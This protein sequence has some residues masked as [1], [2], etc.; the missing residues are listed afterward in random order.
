MS[1]EIYTDVPPLSDVMKPRD[2][3]LF[4]LGGA[5]VGFVIVAISVWAL[6]SLPTILWSGLFP[7]DVGGTFLI[8]EHFRHYVHWILS[9]YNAAGRYFPFYW[10]FYTAQYSIF[11]L[12]VGSYF[13]VQSL[14]FLAAALLTCQIIYRLSGRRTYAA[15][16]LPLIYVSSP[17]AENLNTIGKAEPL[18]YLFLLL[19]MGVFA[20]RY[21][22][23][24]TL[25]MRD[26]VV[27]VAVFALAIWTKETSSVLLGFALTG[28]TLSLIAWKFAKLDFARSAAKMYS[29][30]AGCLLLGFACAKI[31]YAIFTK[32]NTVTLYTTYDVTIKLIKENLVF[33]VTQQPDVLFFGVLALLL[34]LLTLWEMY[35]RRESRT[36]EAVRGLIFV[37][38]VCAMSW[39]Y[40]LALLIWRWAMPYYMLIPAILFKFC[41]TY[42][43]YASSQ[44]LRRSG[45]LR[46]SLYSSTVLFALV[47]ALCTFYV[48]TSQIQYSRIY[49]SAITKYKQIAAGKQNLVIESYPFYAEQIVNTANL[50]SLANP[51]TDR[52]K[53]I[54]DLLDPGVLNAEL[55]KVIGVTPAQIEENKQNLP[56]KGDY[57][58]VFTGSKLA[59][60]FLRGVTPYYSQDSLL[61]QQKM[62]PMHLVSE[63][64]MSNPAVFIHTWTHR[65]KSATTWLGYK[66]YQVDGIEPRYFW[67]GRYPDGW[68]GRS[69]SLRINPEF[70]QPVIVHISAPSFTLPNRVTITK[71]GQPFQ[72]VDLTDANEKTIPLR[73]SGRS[74]D[75][76]DFAIERTAIP[77]MLG[78]ADDKRELGIRISLDIDG[79]PNT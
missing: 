24:A 30:L 1:K 6:F 26:G 15:I 61:K 64:S 56:K 4:S 41:V 52:V 10:L 49:T 11:G 18:S 29:A 2:T 42:W 40:Y 66:L 68:L 45:I 77:K 46:Y 67:Q 32:T 5:G 75:V 55:I 44:R 58:L 27:I 47:G 33:Y 28:A 36:E 62:Y 13:F 14:V 7:L 37:L 76:F 43:I 19:I 54:A 34:P 72:V 9:P 20:R 70:D 53:G 3:A 57:L 50:L 8:G 16:L 74:T 78:F 69:G 65:P 12:H 73:A 31:P 39:A 60:W 48:T 63:Q 79:L 17:V 51:I 25:K 21:L 71:N 23:N 35:S 38:S 22:S 59:T